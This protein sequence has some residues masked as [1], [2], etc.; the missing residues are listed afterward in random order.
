MSTMIVQLPVKAHQ[1]FKRRCL[2]ME[3]YQ[4]EVVKI[5]IELFTSGRLN[6]TDGK[7]E[8]V[9]MASRGIQ[10]DDIC[11]AYNAAAYVGVSYQTIR[12]MIAKN[13]LKARKN[14]PSYGGLIFKKKDL[15]RLRDK[16]DSE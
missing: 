16:F 4:G 3:V 13:K 7:I 1:R 14:A 12:R 5:L 6:I 11:G 9:V 2:D 8:D 10:K 15:D